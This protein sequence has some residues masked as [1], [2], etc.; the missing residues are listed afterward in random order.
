MCPSGTHALKDFIPS[1][2]NIVAA[3]L[4]HACRELET[5]D[6]TRSA[7]FRKPTATDAR[8]IN[9]ARKL[10]LIQPLHASRMHG[11]VIGHDRRS[12]LSPRIVAQPLAERPFR[13]E[14]AHGKERRQE[15]IFHCHLGQYSCSKR[16][17]NWI[18]VV[19][20]DK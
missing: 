9:T 5:N 17:K 10:L 14:N 12:A 15:R 20:C 13:S 19:S 2:L 3:A 8:K 16:G 6:S 4:H 1:Y 18:H 11:A 7:D